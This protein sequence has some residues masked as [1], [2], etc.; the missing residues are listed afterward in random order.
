MNHQKEKHKTRQNN[1]AAKH[2]IHIIMKIEICKRLAL[3]LKKQRSTIE[4][5]ISAPK[6]P[7]TGAS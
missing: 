4:A 7:V 1:V 6:P 2:N 5:E 3:T